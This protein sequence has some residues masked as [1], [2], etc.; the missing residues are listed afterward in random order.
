MIF[1]NQYNCLNLQQKTKQ[2]KTLTICGMRNLTLIVLFFLLLTSCGTL[3]FSD[4]P[5]GVIEYDVTYISNKS[6]MPTNLL[7]K[8]V[9]LKFRAN[10]SITSI[11]GFMGMFSLRNISDLKKHTNTMMLKVMDNK[12]YCEGEKNQSPF[13][14]D[15]LN[16]IKITK[17]NESKSIAGLLCHK[18]IVTSEK[19]KIEP[20]E[21]YYT[22]EIKIK[23]PNKSTPFGSIDG[24]LMQF[25]IQL[26]NIEMKLTATKYT[27]DQV[28]SDL[29]EIPKEYKSISRNKLKGVLVKLLE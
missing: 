17:I 20:F 6:S 11:N 27:K 5:Q 21:L 12:Y 4:Q 24:V 28:N 23:N 14:F 7:P 13:F 3:D 9:V 25:N 2:L 19:S 8:K 10:K 22:N 15:G 29:F 1:Q 18:A 16:E 26:S